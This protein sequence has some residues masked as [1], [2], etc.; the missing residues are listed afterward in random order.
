MRRALIGSVAMHAT[1][2]AVV[3]F[4][5]PDLAHREVEII[6]ITLVPEMEVAERTQAPAQ[7]PELPKEPPPE[8][9]QKPPPPPEPQA[10]KPPPPPPPPPPEPVPEPQ[11]A[12]APPEPKPEPAPEPEPEPEKVAT[13]PPPPPKPKPKRKVEVAKD[14]PKPEPQPEPEDTFLRDLEEKLAKAPQPEPEKKED[15]FLD[16][17]DDLLDSLPKDQRQAQSTTRVAASNAPIGS[18]LT[19]SEEDAIR[20]HVE[21]R[22]NANFGAKGVREMWVEL[23]IR[24]T[25]SGAVVSVERLKSSHSLANP[26]FQSF[27]ESA[28]RA[29]WRSEPLPIPRQKFPLFRNGFV[30]KFSPTGMNLL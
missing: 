12:L 22:W 15:D 27:V 11:V 5:L 7:A 25:E 30:M 2:M 24:V 4:G 29:I 14:K 28:Q 16:S 6:P 23:R 10:A 8:P 18:R 21:E 3:V 17:M 9:K 20:R 19:I 1:V 26:T 13:P